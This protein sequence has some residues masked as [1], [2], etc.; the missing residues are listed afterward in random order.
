MEFW[1]LADDQL[2]GACLTQGLVAF[3]AYGRALALLGLPGLGLE[4]EFGMVAARHGRE[5]V[6]VVVY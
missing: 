1:A 5:I 2:Q 4:H 6:V 3:A